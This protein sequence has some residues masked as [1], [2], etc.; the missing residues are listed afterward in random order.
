MGQN[1]PDANRHDPKVAPK[2][3]GLE[4]RHIRELSGVLV[5]YV[6]GALPRGLPI[7]PVLNLYT[8]VL[9]CLYVLL[10]CATLEYMLLLEVFDEDGI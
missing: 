7:P 1:R 5:Q 8:T 3:S 6:K 10:G 9:Y 2:T 4:D